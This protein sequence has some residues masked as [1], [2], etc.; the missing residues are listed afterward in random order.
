[1]WRG[2]ALTFGMHNELKAGREK[3]LAQ[4]WL[5]SR[6]IDFCKIEL[7]RPGDEPD[8]I[9]TTRNAVTIGIEVTVAY[10][11]SAH[12]KTSWEAARHAY[13][14]GPAKAFHTPVLQDFDESLKREVSRL[15][16]QKVGKKYRNGYS[17]ILLVHLDALLT[18]SEF[19]ENIAAELRQ[20]LH[21]ERFS[22]IWL[23][24]HKEYATYQTWRVV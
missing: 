16:T 10:Y 20:N 3:V 19:I 24:K 18:D 9:V 13:Q 6:G 23:M 22:E 1:M 15:I 11:G 5:E 12:A 8:V 4:R 21:Q 17:L 2:S 7:G 14:R